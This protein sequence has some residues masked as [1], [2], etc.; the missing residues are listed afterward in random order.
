M[1]FVGNGCSEQSEDAIPQGVCHITIIPMDGIHHDLQRGVDN[2][3]GF[4]GVEA[5]NQ[6]R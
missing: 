1:V 6:G 5:F 4:L 2:R 3:S